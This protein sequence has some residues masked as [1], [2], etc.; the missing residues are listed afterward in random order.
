V[1]SDTAGSIEY[2]ARIS[3]G[4]FSFFLDPPIWNRL[5]PKALLLSKSIYPL[6][7]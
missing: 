1:L 4:D 3:S 2:F 7:L 6:I 5:P